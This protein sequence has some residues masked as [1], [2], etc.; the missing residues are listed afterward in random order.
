MRSSIFQD[1]TLCFFDPEDGGNIFHPKLSTD[2]TT[3]IP[4]DRTLQV[5]RYNQFTLYLLYGNDKG[6]NIFG[7]WSHA[8]ICP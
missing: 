8:I 1:T 5:W 6:I 3:F 2:N 7:R 4:A